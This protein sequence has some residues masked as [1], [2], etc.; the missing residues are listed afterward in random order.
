M[1]SHEILNRIALRQAESGD[2]EFLFRL[3]ASTR[4]E[5]LAAVPWKP[6][7][8]EAFLRQQFTAQHAFWK[9]HYAGTSFDLLL[10]DGEPAGR[11][12]VARWPR[13]LRIVD[14]ALVPEHRGGGIGTALIQRLFTE[15][16]RE[17]KPVRIHVE[18]FNPA[19]RLYDR[20]GFVQVEDK[21]VYLLMERPPATDL[22]PVS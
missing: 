18:V 8:K 2:T 15:A 1:P 7:E 21:G 9:E 6:A 12:Y 5:E 4:E 11:L 20:L 22:V 17:G 16:D 14:I 3:Y 19:R 10:V 13:E